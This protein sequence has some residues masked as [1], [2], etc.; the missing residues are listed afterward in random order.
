MVGNECDRA[1][2]CLCT[3]HPPC[4]KQGHA[5]STRP[6]LKGRGFGFGQQVVGPVW[7]S[8]C[9]TVVLRVNSTRNRLPALEPL[10]LGSL[11]VPE[12]GAVETHRVPTNRAHGA[13]KFWR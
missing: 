8:D 11:H 1:V 3:R 9:G 13:E 6:R 7:S 2:L 4:P 10:P 5:E 12:D